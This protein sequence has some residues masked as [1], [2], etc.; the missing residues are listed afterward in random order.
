MPVSPPACGDDGGARRGRGWFFLARRVAPAGVPARTAVWGLANPDVRTVELL[1]P[2]AER[3][4][5]VVA[6]SRAFLAV[7]SPDVDPARLRVRAT[8]ADGRVET[9]TGSAHLVEAP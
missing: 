5:L 8:F 3:R 9:A 2:E 4:R 1:G 7:L 6:P